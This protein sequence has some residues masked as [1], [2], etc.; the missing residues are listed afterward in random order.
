MKFRSH[1]DMQDFCLDNQ[2]DGRSSK[3]I[4]DE[5]ILTIDL[6]MMRDSMG[7]DADV[8][9]DGW[10]FELK[11][12]KQASYRLKLKLPFQVDDEK[13]KASFDKDKRK[14][15]ITM[16]T[17]PKRRESVKFV[18]DEPDHEVFF[19][20]KGLSSD[21]SLD[22]EHEV[23]SDRKV[24]APEDIPS[25]VTLKT[26]TS[27]S[28]GE[29]TD[30][31]SPSVKKTVRFNDEVQRQIY[32]SNSS[33]L[34]QKKKNQRKAKNKRKARERLNS[35]ESVS[36]MDDDDGRLNRNHGKNSRERFNSG[37]SVSSMDDEGQE[38]E[39]E[40][41]TDDGDGDPGPGEEQGS[42]KEDEE[43]TDFNGILT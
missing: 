6:P 12:E 22:L 11:S 23:N 25:R 40:K 31:G 37:G 3:P 39:N 42:W 24:S 9:E 8:V 15:M 30:I 43:S 19:E 21:S 27:S 10:Y 16:K 35:G 38:N 29:S 18:P 34:G 4:P 13:S 28:S 41:E 2:R 1:V 17:I 20:S 5:I 33:I 14:L 32:R 26:V 36:S 7:L